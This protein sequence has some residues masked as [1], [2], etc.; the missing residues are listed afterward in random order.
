MSDEIK[1]YNNMR[2]NNP[3]NMTLVEQV[4]KVREE[5]CDNLCKYR[6]RA[7]HGD[8]SSDDLEGI[9]LNKCPMRYL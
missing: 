6:E 2:R 9:C 3:L 7:E 1:I 5:V 4:S 8:I